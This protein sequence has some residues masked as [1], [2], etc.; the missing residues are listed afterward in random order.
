MMLAVSF[1]ILP[2]VSIR[3][4]DYNTSVSESARLY[5]SLSYY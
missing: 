3:P 5:N 1:L 2:R 4:R